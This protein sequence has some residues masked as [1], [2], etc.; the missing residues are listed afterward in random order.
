MRPI[1]L[2]VN[3]IATCAPGSLNLL[4]APEAQALKTETRG[5]DGEFDS[6]EGGVTHPP[7]PLVRE[8]TQ[9]LLQEKGEHKLPPL[10]IRE[11]VRG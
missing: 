7:G 2:A 4:A 8:R 5:S 3:Q 10:F 1:W 9:G 6:V 11:G